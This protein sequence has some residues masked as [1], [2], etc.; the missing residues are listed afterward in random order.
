MSRTLVASLASPSGHYTAKVYRNAKATTFK[1]VAFVDGV[2]HRYA[3]MVNF[4]E[5]EALEET[6]L[7]LRLCDEMTAGLASRPAA[8]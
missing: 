6:H 7:S 5:A 2:P 8:Q 4:S 3:D 1:T